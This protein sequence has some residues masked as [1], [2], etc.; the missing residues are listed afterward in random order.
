M[1]ILKYFKVKKVKLSFS[2]N[3]YATFYVQPSEKIQTIDVCLNDNS[4]YSIF[5]DGDLIPTYNLTSKNTY[6]S[7]KC[8]KCGFICQTM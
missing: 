3:S 7:K 8:D 1:N 2:N 5:I 6:I 4:A